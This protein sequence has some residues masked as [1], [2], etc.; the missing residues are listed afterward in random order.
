MMFTSLWNMLP[1][2]QEPPQQMTDDPMSPVTSVA[3][4][5]AKLHLET[6]PQSP[7]S[8]IAAGIAALRID[9]DSMPGS[10]L[11]DGA[12]D[13][14]HSST[15][16]Q[17]GSGE[18]LELLETLITASSLTTSSIDSSNHNKLFSSAAEFYKGAGANI[19]STV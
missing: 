10:F 8:Q 17:H 15:N 13:S 2:R 4:K 12:A 3:A 18:V 16:A 14:L 19:P 6:L 9:E 11:L 5:M 7:R 1:H